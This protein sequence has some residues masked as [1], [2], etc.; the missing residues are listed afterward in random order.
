[1]DIKA[2]PV[3]ESPAFLSAGSY[4]GIYILIGVLFL[5]LVL[6]VF[7][8]RIKVILSL[9]VLFIKSKN[10]N[11]SEK[12]LLS[13]IYVVVPSHFY[14]SLSESDANK[15]ALIKYSN[16]SLSEMGFVQRLI[17][18]MLALCVSGVRR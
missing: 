7:N 6:L 9:C 13:Q 15:I 1:L 14:N 11:S 18:Q 10:K 12:K 5:L 4:Y 2:I 8:K 3:V 17:K 16:K